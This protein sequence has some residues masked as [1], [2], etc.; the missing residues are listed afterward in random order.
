MINV[1]DYG[2]VGDGIT[3]DTEAIQKA[4][5]AANGD[6][7]LLPPGIYRIAGVLICKM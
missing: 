2:A 7:V 3:D 6:V 5:D 4:L 1:I